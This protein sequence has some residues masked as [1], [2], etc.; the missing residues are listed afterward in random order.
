VLTALD[1]MHV[2]GLATLALQVQH[3]LFGC[4]C[5]FM[6]HWLGLTS[7]TCLLFV[8]TTLSL[9]IQ[10][11]LSSLV[12]GHLVYGVLLAGFTLA[13]GFFSLW[14]IDLQYMNEPGVNIT[15]KDH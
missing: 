9:G 8:V 1:G 2:S 5:L 6:E 15:F 10:G 13:I 11:S 3:N 7:E 14:N 4:L 12:L